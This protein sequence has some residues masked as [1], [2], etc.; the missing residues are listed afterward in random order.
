MNGGGAPSALA[1]TPANGSAPT[2]REDRRVPDVMARWR[3]R[4]P[5][6]HGNEIV[7]AARPVSI[8]WTLRASNRRIAE[9]RPDLV[10]S[11]A[12]YTAVDQARRRARCW[13]WPQMAGPGVIGRAATK[14]GAPV[15]HLSTDYVFD[16]SGMTWTEDDVTKPIGTYGRTKLA[17]EEAYVRQSARYAILRTAW[18]Y[19]PFGNNFVKTMYRLCRN[20]DVLNVVD[21]QYG[22]PTTLDI[23]DALMALVMANRSPPRREHNLSPCRNRHVDR[24]NF[25]RSSSSPQR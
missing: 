21:D 24:V 5:N 1:I 14:M 3:S 11:A 18:V 9:F 4:W 22:N 8:F 7:F 13:Q 16:G 15:L 20:H 25:A 2:R 10:I 19:S 6:A 23:A 12:A 17:G